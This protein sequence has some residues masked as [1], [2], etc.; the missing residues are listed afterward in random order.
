M[1]EKDNLNEDSH[2]LAI[3]SS[4]VVSTSGIEADNTFKIETLEKVLEDSSVESSYKTYKSSADT[5][6]VGSSETFIQ[7]SEDVTSSLENVAEGSLL[8][9]ESQ[10]QEQVESFDVDS[11]QSDNRIENSVLVASEGLDEPSPYEENTI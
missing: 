9:Q 4:N 6:V 7:P 1:L 2:T 3:E 8:M 10:K 5:Q 11:S